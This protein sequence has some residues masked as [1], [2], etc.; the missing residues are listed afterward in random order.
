[1]MNS[2]VVFDGKLVLG[3]RFEQEGIFPYSALICWNGV[4]WDSLGA[5]LSPD[6]FDQVDQMFVFGQSL[7]VI[8]KLRASPFRIVVASWDGQEWDLLL[9]GDYFETASE[10]E[11][12]LVVGG[13]LNSFGPDT[14]G[15]A[16]LVNG[17][18]QPIQNSPSPVTEMLPSQ[19]S[20]VLGGRF[21]TAEGSPYNHLAA[22]GG[23]QFRSF[24][25]GLSDVVYSLAFFEDELFV[26]GSFAMAGG[27]PSSRIAVW[28]G[29]SLEVMQDNMAVLPREF[30]LSQNFPNPFNGE[31]Q[32]SLSLPE[33]GEI[34]VNILNI[35]GQRI[36]TLYSDFLVR[37]EHSMLWD[38]RTDRGK[39]VPS[40]VYFLRARTELQTEFKKMLFLK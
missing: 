11:G 30:S 18:W 16:M 28:Q 2:I 14:C 37:G 23:E 34:T 13:E 32:F 40:G 22:W 27:H 1:M 29:S 4:N 8:G 39:S 10:W 25:E 38:G 20:L 31:T 21:S 35:L 5:R 6:G 24:G 17:E 33:S 15:L 36:T 3:G 12:H 19:N 26:G 7:I 9:D